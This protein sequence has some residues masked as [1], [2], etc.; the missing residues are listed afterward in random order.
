MDNLITLLM[1][2]GLLQF[3]WFEGVPFKLHLDMLPAYPD[4]LKALA[5]A[6]KT[7]TQPIHTLSR[8]VSTNDALPFGVA[9]SLETGIPLVYSRGSGEGAVNDLV[10]AYDIGHPALMLVNTWTRNDIQR[11]SDLITGARRVGLDIRQ[12]LTI[13]EV[14]TQ[15][16]HLGVDVSVHHL[17]KLTNIVE[18]LVDGGRMPV[19]QGEAVLDWLADR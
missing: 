9:L 4:V 2:A 18:I 7:Q 17:L 3:G 10:G 13:V 1:D 19:G 15:N 14:D 6:A 11:V 8:L 12:A 16:T 5:V